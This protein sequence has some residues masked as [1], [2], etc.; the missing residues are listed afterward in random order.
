MAYS[1][2]A[3]F[4]P[5]PKYYTLLDPGS[6]NPEQIVRTKPNTAPFLSNCPRK[7]EGGAKL[8]TQAVY[9]WSLPNNLKNYASML[10]KKPR[11]P[12]EAFSAEDLEEI[13][14]RCGFSTPCEC[15][16]GEEIEPEV[17]CQ[18][19]VKRRLF[20]GITPRYG[21]DEGLSTPSRND[22][23]FD[24]TPEGGQ[25]RIREEIKQD[26]PP[27]YDT[28]VI[29]STA[30]YQ[31]CKWSK[32]TGKDREHVKKT[33]GPADYYLE[34]EPTREEICAE[35]I[36]ALKR[37]TTRQ[38]RFMEMV[39]QRTIRENLPSPAT[40][41][42]MSPRGTD[43]K[44]LGPKAERFPN[45]KSKYDRS[46][47]PADHWL[48]RDFDAVKP[49]DV[50]CHAN[51]P[52]PAC[53]GNKAN[54][55]KIQR[56]E[57]P[58]PATYHVNTRVCNFVNCRTAGFGTSAKRFKQDIIIEESDDVE[59]VE[60]KN[61]PKPCILPTWGFRSKTVRMKPLVKKLYE[62]S[63]A[64]FIPK[65]TSVG[66]SAELQTAAPF[67]TSERRFNPWFSSM[68]VHGILETPGPG[69]YCLEKPECFPAFK[70]GPLYRAKRF[71]SILHKGPP[72]NEY[73]VCN[74]IE[75]I[76]ATHNDKLKNNIENKY[77]FIWKQ[78]KPKK[79]LTFEE[80]E[81]LLLRQCIAILDTDEEKAEKPT[82]KEKVNGSVKTKQ[83]M[84]RYFLYAHPVP[85]TI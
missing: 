53:F 73:E 29:E 68:P 52:E 11:F 58:S 34:R 39:Q 14:C 17:I 32:R 66:R 61:K 84:L 18:G 9:D 74:G 43:L 55:F 30:F 71:S 16:T 10:S 5:P 21:F 83:K 65:Q 81:K 33:P 44:C 75:T 23:G 47:G 8:W 50:L 28:K 2:A 76:L 42:P 27:F 51:L 78:P 48:R 57:G 36:R 25:Y 54:R 79:V 24:I 12:Y 38:T 7:I 45:T 41:R 46:P 31:G 70:R 64:D 80:R 19:K 63:P 37:K 13:L 56:E 77:K 3:R 82:H 69:Y 72:P 1:L 15:P 49:P 67:Y 26:C 6:Y 60:P 4:S 85:L 22:H 35:K 20:K 59:I 62:Q 40:Y